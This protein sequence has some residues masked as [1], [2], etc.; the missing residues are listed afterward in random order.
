MEYTKGPW[1]YKQNRGNNIYEHSVFTNEQVI[2]ELNCSKDIKT[3]G[4]ID[5]S[6]NI[7][8]NARLIAAA[9]E[10]YEECKKQL[11]WLEHIKTQIT[12]PTTVCMGFDQSIKYLQAVIAKAEGR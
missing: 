3:S 9:P 2:A 4:M 10:M 12:A 1:K 8:A 6:E 11:D 5:I 7:K